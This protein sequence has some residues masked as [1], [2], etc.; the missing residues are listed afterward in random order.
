[1]YKGGKLTFLLADHHGTSTTRIT[2]DA[3]QTITRRKTTIFGGP[4]GTQPDNWIGDKGFVG[5]TK[6]P[7]I[8]ECE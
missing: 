7:D 3:T 6:D 1:M 2:N 8:K 4:R 5:G